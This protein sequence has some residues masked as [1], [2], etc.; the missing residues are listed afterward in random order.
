[1]KPVA[2]LD[3]VLIEPMRRTLSPAAQFFLDILRA[4][5]TRLNDVWLTHFDPTR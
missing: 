4:E 1:V 5:E 2:T 3:L